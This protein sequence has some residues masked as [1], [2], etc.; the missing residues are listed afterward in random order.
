[1]S[2]IWTRL[3]STILKIRSRLD[4]LGVD[5]ILIYTAFSISTLT[6]VLGLFKGQFGDED[7]KI[8]AAI[9]AA[10]GS[11]LYGGQLL[12]HGPLPFLFAG[13]GYRIQGVLGSL[14][15]L[16]LLPASLA[17]LSTLLIGT[18]PLIRS[19]WL[20]GYAAL[21]WSVFLSIFWTVKTT[22]MSIYHGLGGL[23]ATVL[24]VGVLLPLERG[25]RQ[26][27]RL[28][29][30]VS[31]IGTYMA[32]ASLTFLPFVL[33]VLATLLIFQLLNKSAPELKYT[34]SRPWPKNESRFYRG[35][36][37]LFLWFGVLGLALFV[38]LAVSGVVSLKGIYSGHIYFNQ[39]IFSKL[40]S[41]LNLSFILHRQEDHFATNSLRL[42]LF[43]GIFVVPVWLQYLPSRQN[44]R[45]Y[46]YALAV[47]PASFGIV[48]QSYRAGLGSITSF[49]ALP[50]LLPAT[51]LLLVGILV[52]YE[53]Y[54][55][56]YLNESRRLLRTCLISVPLTV[57]I[58]FGIY[59]ASDPEFSPSTVYLFSKVNHLLVDRPLSW[60]P[61]EDEMVSDL[62]A[63]IES[64]APDRKVKLF[65][66][67]FHPI[68]FAIY[69]RPSAYPVN[70][71][72][73]YNELVE[74]DTTLR[75]YHACN[76]S[77]SLGESPDILYYAEWVV[78]GQDSA[79]YGKCLINI[80]NDR[81]VRLSDK[82]YLRKDHATLLKSFYEE[83]PQYKNLS[84]ILEPLN[85]KESEELPRHADPVL[86]QRNHT[87]QY[88]VVAQRDGVFDV[89]G[90][91]L[92][93]FNAIH[94]GEVYVCL[95]LLPSDNPVCSD[96][97]DMSIVRDV[98]MTRFVL[99]RPLSVKSGTNLRLSLV[100]V[101]DSDHAAK[102]KGNISILVVP[103]LMAPLVFT[104]RRDGQLPEPMEGHASIE[105]ALHAPSIPTATIP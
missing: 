24:V 54:Q 102:G 100:S 15:A 65:A 59:R 69:N 84:T 90:L 95:N 66:W 62:I 101:N 28:I 46:L 8:A 18:T 88:K 74:K 43:A 55:S 70:W 97:V 82:I 6:V 2:L 38:T 99:S 52:I 92:P 85:W 71:F 79:K 56:L 45:P 17:I 67:P 51:A 35:V 14:A 26:F 77:L 68:F 32:L 40:A 48:F 91:T 44:A 81:Y 21:S 5:N 29:L 53:D 96:K 25:G 86:L 89:L 20:R 63:E 105:G 98:E 7:E 39:S 13:L 73:W 11:S 36:A 3:R 16:R 33:S 64:R 83:Y 10:Q 34:R 37:S 103:R 60:R 19:A 94:E 4:E 50:Y 61:Y 104:G 30:G 31:V 27:Y 1:M 93:V 58:F 80:M 87:T 75:R 57:M 12:N 9:Y 78:N 72:L 42:I 22:Q 23:F 76:P 49:Y 41:P 47:L